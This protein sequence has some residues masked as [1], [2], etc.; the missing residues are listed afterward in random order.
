MD[1]VDADAGQIVITKLDVSNSKVT[2]A[3]GLYPVEINV[4]LNHGADDND[5]VTLYVYVDGE[6]STS[7]DVTSETNYTVKLNA[8]ANS[9]IK[10][11]VSGTQT[12]ERGVYFY[13]PEP[14]DIDGDGIAT[15]REVSQNLIGV[16]SGETPVYAE[17]TITLRKIDKYEE[18]FDG[19][20]VDVTL[21]VNGKVDYK[22]EGESFAGA[23]I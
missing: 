9:T 18:D 8:K 20:Y 16:G 14:Q 7:V 3:D 13:Q 12:L 5:N 11:V 15:S 6:P 21:E 4:S 10:V 19:K 17:E 23:I 22:T 1:G 2:K